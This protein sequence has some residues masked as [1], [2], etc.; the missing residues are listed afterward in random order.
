VENGW[1]FTTNL[2]VTS[3]GLGFIWSVGMLVWVLFWGLN[4]YMQWLNGMWVMIC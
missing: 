4:H 1:L 3:M 2:V